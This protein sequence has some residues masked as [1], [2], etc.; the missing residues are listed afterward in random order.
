MKIFLFRGCNKLGF[1]SVFSQLLARTESGRASTESVLLTVKFVTAMMT[2]EMGRTSPTAR[3]D[4][5]VGDYTVIKP[6]SVILTI[7]F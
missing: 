6:L 7:Y 1:L 4:V 2:V 3:H 5:V